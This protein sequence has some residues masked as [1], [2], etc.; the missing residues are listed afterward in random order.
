MNIIDLMTVPI[1]S[2]HVQPAVDCGAAFLTTGGGA[3][4]P[5]AAAGVGPYIRRMNWKGALLGAGSQL[6]YCAIP[7]AGAVE[8]K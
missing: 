3:K 2:R 7:F 8:A 5:A 4:L 6:A 1:S